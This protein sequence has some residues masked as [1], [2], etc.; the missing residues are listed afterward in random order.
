MKFKITPEQ[1]EYMDIL[2]NDCKDKCPNHEPQYYANLL[3]NAPTDEDKCNIIINMLDTEYNIPRYKDVLMP[4]KDLLN[5]IKE[6]NKPSIDKG[7]TK[8]KDDMNNMRTEILNDTNVPEF[9]K[10]NIRK[11]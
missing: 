1:Q 4:Y 3:E 7:L 6:A 8:I 11:K 2:V 10:D 9:V 5:Q